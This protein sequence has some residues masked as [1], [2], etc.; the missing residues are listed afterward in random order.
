MQASRKAMFGA[1][2]ALLCVACAHA[3]PPARAAASPPP[4]RRT[5]LAI[6]PVESD[7]FPELA[8]WVSNLLEEAHVGGVDERF[9]SKVTL[10][11]VQLSIECVD[12]TPAC[13]AAA[14]KSLGASRLLFAQ[15]GGGAGRRRDRSVH[16]TVTLFDATAGTPLRVA[17]A[18]YK[19]QNEALAS[20]EELVGRA[21]APGA[22]Q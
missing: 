6:L 21:I 20:V 10:E 16:V 19:D 1:L 14:G 9:Q 3:P 2:S 11:V 7:N 12:S 4:S 18:Q 8:E 17:D 13:Y 22:A 5:R 15:I